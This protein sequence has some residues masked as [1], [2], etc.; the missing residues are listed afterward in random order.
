MF[1]WQPGGPLTVETASGKQLPADL[2]ML[3]I[4]VRPETDLAKAAGLE[5]GKRGGIKVDAHMR[6]SDPDIYA[7]GEYRVGSRWTHK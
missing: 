3:V 5:L 2:V 6:T 1:F 7:V 4:G